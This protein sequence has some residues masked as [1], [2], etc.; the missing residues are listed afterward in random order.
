MT[1]DRP[2]ASSL[3]VRVDKLDELITALTDARA[4]LEVTA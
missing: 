4:S 1:K 2:E 3:Y